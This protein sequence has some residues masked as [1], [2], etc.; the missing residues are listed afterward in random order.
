[1]GDFTSEQIYSTSPAAGAALG[2]AL[3]QGQES[4]VFDAMTRVHTEASVKTPFHGYSYD[5]ELHLRR[6]VETY[7]TG[8][9]APLHAY[10][11]VATLQLR[12]VTQHEAASQAIGI[13]NMLAQAQANPG[14]LL[15]IILAD[16]R[17][18]YQFAR[19]TL[20]MQ[21]D[22]SAEPFRQQREEMVAVAADAVR[23][24]AM[25]EADILRVIELS[26]IGG[27]FPGDGDAELRALDK[28]HTPR[29][30][31]VIRL[32][33]SFGFVKTLV[34]PYEAAN[35]DGLSIVHIQAYGA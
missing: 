22:A 24:F 10:A 35:R 15:T 9:V 26:P 20:A 32:A 18:S 2:E 27:F 3:L 7:G 28:R 23:D 30:G 13:L 14:R 6:L 16:L 5:H 33:R 29:S 34:E 21:T 12:H 8:A 31:N 19:D 11:N 25:T 17:R 4:D 1:M